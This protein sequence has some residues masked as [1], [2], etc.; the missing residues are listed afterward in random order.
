MNIR[1]PE[2]QKITLVSSFLVGVLY[3]FFFTTYA[4]YTLKSRMLQLEEQRHKVE[5][6]Q[7]EVAQ[8][9]AAVDRL[10]ELER[11]VTT[12]HRRWD[13]VSELLPLEKETAS[14]L[15]R[16]TVAGQ[17]SGV[18]FGLVEPQ[19]PEDRGFYVA[20]PTR[21]QVDGGYHEV[22]RFLAEV[23]NSSRIVQV[24]DLRL[25]AGPGAA[26]QGERTVTAAFVA[27][28]Y[29]GKATESASAE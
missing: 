23:G 13:E 10:P 5:R 28:A 26:G 18:E 7:V 11:E 8:A 15:A 19:P 21:I 29:A 25:T 1:D 27:E 22:G 9:R 12:I 14:F 3:L 24:R 17:E 2:V 20:F 6:L 16:L 4:P